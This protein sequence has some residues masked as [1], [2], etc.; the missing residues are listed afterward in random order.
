MNLVEFKRYKGNIPRVGGLVIL[1]TMILQSLILNEGDSRLYI[2][3]LLCGFPV[4]LSGFAEDLYKNINP[5]IRLSASILTGMIF[6]YLS[7]FKITN[8][9]MYTFD[10][11]VLSIP[12]IAFILTS[13]SIASLSQSFNI[14]D[15]L[16]GLS[17]GTALICISAIYFLSITHNDME[18]QKITTYL[19]FLPSFYLYITFRMVKYF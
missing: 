1:L 6:V 10:L 16:N 14:I 19:F 8:I 7:H 2:I 11:Y 13:L 12:S 17:I 5:Y 3:L 9:N 4:F 15:G 18:L